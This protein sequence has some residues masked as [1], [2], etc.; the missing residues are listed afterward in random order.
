MSV[1]CILHGQNDSGIKLENQKF[2]QDFEDVT[3]DVKGAVGVD[4]LQTTID[5][6]IVNK[7]NPHNVTAK[8][9]GAIG[10]EDI[11]N[12]Y[13]WEKSQ[14]VTTPATDG[15]VEMSPPRRFDSS[16]FANFMDFCYSD[17][18]TVS[19]NL[20]VYLGVGDTRLTTLSEVIELLRTNPPPSLYFTIDVGDL[21]SSN[22]YLLTDWYAI[23]PDSM[24]WFEGQQLI[25]VSPAAPS[26]TTTTIIGYPTS[27]SKTTYPSNGS[28]N[29]YD[30]KLKGQIGALL[31]S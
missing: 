13:L 2:I 27:S 24:S 20:Q 30:Y 21:T 12:L 9:T 15:E 16:D 1:S 31:N 29:G 17:S 7:S 10:E 22:V 28:K 26:T 23:I 18:Y 6:H 14:T 5:T 3:K 19:S 4:T 8:Q 25:G 11:G